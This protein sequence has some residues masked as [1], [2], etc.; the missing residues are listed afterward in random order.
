MGCLSVLTAC[1]KDSNNVIVPTPVL[2][3]K[4]VTYEIFSD[5]DYTGPEGDNK[6]VEIKL[7]LGRINKKTGITEIVFDTT[8]TMQ[9]LRNLPLEEHKLSIQKSIP[10]INNDLELLQVSYS[11]RTIVNGFTS[12]YAE[13]VPMNEKETSKMVTIKL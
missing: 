11:I 1:K 6:F 3:S 2:E 8:L 5:H 10:N 12:T 13:G 7:G 4:I 9:P